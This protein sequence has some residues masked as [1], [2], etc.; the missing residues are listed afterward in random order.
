LIELP[1]ASSLLGELLV[2]TEPAGA[3]VTVDGHVYGKSPLTVEGLSPGTHSVVLENELGSMT[4]EVKIEA[5]TTASLV[6]PLSASKNAPVSGW[7]AV[8]APMP[9]QIFEDGRLL[10]TS[11]SERI[12]VSV[13]R[14]ELVMAN[15]TVGFSSKHVVNVTPGNVSSIRPQW[16]AGTMSFNATPWAEVW[17]N[18][19]QIGETPLGNVSVPIGAHEVLFRHPELGEKHIRAVVTLA[20][21]AKVSVDMRQR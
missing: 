15:E 18:G 11:Q 5:G 20:A 14:H 2:R 21:P 12:M 8:N 7:I 4:Q 6:V 10:G 9:L 1:R 19:R 17:V 16:P 13:G 3:Q